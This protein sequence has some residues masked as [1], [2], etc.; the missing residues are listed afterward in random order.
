MVGFRLAADACCADSRVLPAPAA[1]FCCKT[2]PTCDIV[3]GSSIKPPALLAKLLIMAPVLAD[4]AVWTCFTS[5]A[6]T[7]LLPLLSRAKADRLVRVC[8][9]AAMRLM[10]PAPESWATSNAVRAS[11]TLKSLACSL[12]DTTSSSHTCRQA[13]HIKTQASGNRCG[14]HS[15][16]PRARFRPAHSR[17]PTHFCTTCTAPQLSCRIVQNGPPLRR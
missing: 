1:A 6:E 10:S 12:M 17:E 13:P 5:P 9:P 14:T 16:P 11:V 3:C 8:A 2:Q 7:P 4:I 15:M